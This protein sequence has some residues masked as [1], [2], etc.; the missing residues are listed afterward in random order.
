MN[1]SAGSGAQADRFHQL[2]RES[3]TFDDKLKPPDL[4]GMSIDRNGLDVAILQDSDL[5]V[6]TAGAGYGKTTLLAQWVEAHWRHSD[7][8]SAWLTITPEDN[9]P[10][11]LVAYLIRA[12]D[13]AW[14]ISESEL[15]SLLAPGT[16]EVSILLPRLAHL[17]SEIPRGS[18]LFIDEV[19]VIDDPRSQRILETIVNS[20]P[21]GSQVLLSGRS[22]PPIGLE[23]MRTQ[24]RV[25]ELHE[26][27]LALSYGE[28]RALVAAARLRVDPDRV[29]HIYQVAEGWP[30]GVYLLALASTQSAV[31]LPN[32]SVTVAAYVQEQVFTGLDAATIDFLTKTSVLDQLDGSICDALLARGDSAQVLAK[33]ADCHLFVVPVDVSAGSYRYHGLLADVLRSELQKDSPITVSELHARA[34]DLFAERGDRG[35][36]VR[37]AI[38]SG[39]IERTAALIWSFLP[40]MLGLGKGDTVVSWLKYLREEEYDHSPVFPVTRMFVAVVAG[41]GR[42]TRLWLDVAHRHQPATPMPDGTPLDFFLK[43][44]EALICDNG[45]SEMVES[46]HEASALIVGSSPFRVLALFLEGSGLSLLG[47]HERAWR[48]LDEAIE[49]GMA[50]PTGGL[51]ALAQRALSAMDDDNWSDARRFV[52]R[53]L[54]IYEHFHLEHLPNQAGFTAA[55]A[56]LAI[57]DDDT[58]LAMNYASRARGLLARIIDMAPWLRLQTVITLAR[59]ELEVGRVPTAEQLASEAHIILQQVPDSIGMTSMLKELEQAIASTPPGGRESSVSLTT[60]EIRLA[61]FL[62]THLT[63]GQIADELYLSINTVKSQAKAI[64]RKMDVESRHAAVVRASEL[65]LLQ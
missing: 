21:S 2:L 11:T 39:D 14:S 16:T 20:V 8:Q 30:A 22:L 47:D 36:A 9:D 38:L 57:H 59:V 61:A 58:E 65:G 54:A 56:W 5:I 7:V 40:I 49:T 45:I 27:E 50:Y 31:E 1:V 63:F 25:L 4:R 37:H 24:R 41:D 53:G 6:L 42:S 10:G 15:A 3:A 35:L 62:P 60:A 55:A 13:K 64:Y 43:L 17:V 51:L 44:G 32:E 46:A 23:R 26:G 18:A 28:A 19:N 12:L 33:L 29:R 52:Q 48:F 34:S